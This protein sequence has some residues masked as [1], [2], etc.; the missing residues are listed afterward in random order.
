MYTGI[1]LG[2]GAS[3]TFEKDGVHSIRG[4]VSKVVIREGQSTP[5]NRVVFTDIGKFVH[6]IEEVV[7]ELKLTT[8]PNVQGDDSQQNFN[9]QTN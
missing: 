6:W 9:H 3:M 2:D 8:D 7:P 4:I 5:S 1:R